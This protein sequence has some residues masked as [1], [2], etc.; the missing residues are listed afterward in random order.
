MKFTTLCGILI[1]AALSANAQPGYQID[2]IPKELLPRASAIIRD[3]D[4]SIEVKDLGNVVYR[5]KKAI[6]V[7]N[8][9]GDD[10]ASLYIWYNKNTQIRYVRGMVYD[11]FSKPLGKIQE[12]DLKD[13]SA[14]SD[15]SLFE[16]SRAKMFRPA[17]IS[18][19]YTIQYEY[20]IAAKHS[21]F[22]PDWFPKSSSEVS[23]EHS[24]FHFISKPDFNIRFKETNYTGD[25]VKVTETDKVKT[26]T[27]NIS[28]MKASRNEPFSNNPDELFTSV[29]VA[30]NVFKYL[31]VDGAF[32]NWAE[33]GK[34]MSDKLLKERNNIPEHTVSYIK[35]LTQNITDPK[36]K[37]KIVYEYVQQKTR[38]ISVQIG[39]GGFQPIKAED[40]DRTSYGDCKGLVNYTQGLLNVVG[41]KSYYAVVFGDERKHSAIPDFASMDQFNHAIL[42]IP[43]Q[44]DTTWIDCTSKYNPFGYLGN[45]TDDRLALICTENGGKLIRTPTFADDKSL[46][47]RKVSFALDPTGNIKG[48]M[49]TTFT[50]SQF[51]NRSDLVN[52]S[53]TEQSKAFTE[54]YSIDN[55]QIEKYQLTQE[56]GKYPVTTE[57]IKISARNYASLNG[58]E[59]HLP[60]NMV[61]RQTPIREINNRINKVYINRG[62]TDSDEITYTLPEGYRLERMPKDFILESIFGTYSA[63]LTRNSDKITYTRIMKLKTGIYPADKYNELVKFYQFASDA[64]SQKIVL[65][66]QQPE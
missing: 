2:R 56:K 31:G 17:I 19:P 28:N 4:L 60:L 10:E 30:P 64:D 13:V 40:V 55:A 58:N 23:V 15:F 43:F 49:T 22:F 3:M 50:G 27:W 1:F 39:I 63:T 9:N 41:I 14:A 65:L 7:L 21:M 33:M 42:C 51:N 38:Y 62:Y 53:I 61:N 11:E 6:T 37:A 25:P 20:E 32:S 29:R 18:Y 35:E 47:N 8:K 57:F 48:D 66:K 26:L 5:Y 45:F 34:W 16:D 52:E 59:F 54:L 46:Q 36:L 24:S 12:G 44:N